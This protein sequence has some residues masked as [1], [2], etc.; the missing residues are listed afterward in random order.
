MRNGAASVAGGARR[1]TIAPVVMPGSTTN[2]SQIS[3]SD[4][5]GEGF[6]RLRGDDCVAEGSNAVHLWGY[7][8]KYSTK[9]GVKRVPYR[10]LNATLSV[11]PRRSSISARRVRASPG[12]R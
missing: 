7:P 10:R 9:F 11:T 4:Q 1:A 2:S 12:D 6:S 3:S 5:S 8:I